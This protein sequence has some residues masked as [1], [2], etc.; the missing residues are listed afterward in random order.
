MS[1]AE[2]TRAIRHKSNSWNDYEWY[3]CTGTQALWW[4]TL[5]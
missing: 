3:C 4:S 5:R 2:S 1:D